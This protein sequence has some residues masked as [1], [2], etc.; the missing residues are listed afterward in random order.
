MARVD[1]HGE[2]LPLYYG[3]HLGRLAAVDA[4][5]ERL[6]GL[7]VAANYRDG[8]SVRDRIACGRARARR[9]AA[10]L[11]HRPRAA[12]DAPNRLYLAEA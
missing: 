10:V 2:A 4:R 9:V 5:L 6:P 1:R 8:V 3:D 12:V 7:H 11:A